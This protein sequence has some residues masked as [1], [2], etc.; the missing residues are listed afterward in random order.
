MQNKNYKLFIGETPIENVED[1]LNKI[2]YKALNQT[3][4]VHFIWPDDNLPDMDEILEI[5]DDVEK[6]M[7]LKCECGA[8]KCNLPYHSDWCPKYENN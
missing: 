6:D 7:N 5:V 2:F 3:L 8:E 4:G 1:Y